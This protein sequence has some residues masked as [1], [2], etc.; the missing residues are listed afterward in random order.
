M[1]LANGWLCLLRVAVAQTEM[2]E[3]ANTLLPMQCS[4]NH[5]RIALSDAV[6]ESMKP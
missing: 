1:A 3:E 6:S 2:R 5:L 4:S